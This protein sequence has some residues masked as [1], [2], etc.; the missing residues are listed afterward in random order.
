MSDVR[1]MIPGPVEADDDVLAAI[2]QQTL[3]HYGP[4]WMALFNETT[5]LLKR[6]FVTDG[7]VLMIPGPGTAG[8]DAAISSLIPRGQGVAVLNN[9]FFGLRFA[10]I[11]EKNGLKP[12]Q[13]TADWGQP[14]TPD[15]VRDQLKSHLRR[16]AIDGAPIRALA[17]CHHET[18]TG[19]LN[20]LQEIAGVAHEFDLP[21]IVDA[22]A[23]F[24]GVPIAVDDWG[25]DVCISVPNKCLGV[26]PGVALVS[27]SE[28]AWDMAEANPDQHGWYLDLRTW[29]W[30]IDNWGDWHPYPTT[31]PTNNIV[32]VHA[33][34]K[35]VFETG[36][37]AYYDSFQAAAEGTRQ[38][39]AKY[40]F[41]LYPE[42]AYAAPLISALKVPAGVDD[43]DLR[44]YLLEEHGLMISGGLVDLKGQIIRVGHMGKGRD[45]AVVEKLI[46][47]VETYMTEKSPA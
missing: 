36:V 40:G 16:A 8:L 38:G 18:S 17:L 19:I 13:I 41:T 28:R 35:K 26:P 43:A 20:P 39:L 2:G 6:L 30:Y 4:Q 7:D 33:G 15:A 44:R 29:R 5:D 47:A 22:V 42:P 12:Y 11:V 9:G 45:V 34:L 21:V 24:G 27:V 25:I 10:E 3:P 31:L 14:L 37:D 23:S 1:L 32:A 46:A